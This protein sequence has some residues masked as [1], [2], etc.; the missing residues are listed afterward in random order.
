MDHIRSEAERIQAALGASQDESVRAV[1]RSAQQALVWA[2]EPSEYTSPLHMIS[3]TREETGDCWAQP[4]R[5][6][7]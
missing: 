1:L 3:G 7:S 4:R 5:S 6:L 2:L